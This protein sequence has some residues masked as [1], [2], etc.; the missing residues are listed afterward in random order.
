MFIALVPILVTVCKG[1][2]LI[3]VPIV[4]SDASNQTPLLAESYTEV[5][6]L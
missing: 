6:G 2:H 1:V 4:K 3:R 5:S